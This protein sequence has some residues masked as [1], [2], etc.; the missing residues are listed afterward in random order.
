MFNFWELVRMEY[1]KLFQRKLVWVTAILLT[2]VTIFAGL[3]ALLGDVYVNGEKV[4]THA[5]MLRTDSGYARRL[6]GELLDDPLLD[7]MQ[8]AYGKVPEDAEIYTAT[9]EYQQYARPY[10]E[11]YNFVLR[12]ANN[13]WN[14]I[15][16]GEM[17][18]LRRAAVEQGW[19]KL[20]L[21]EAEKEYLSG[22]EGQLKLPL[23]Y[24]YD[25]G[26]SNY[27]S[28]LYM[29]ALLMMLGVSVCV[30]QIF[31]EEYSRKT[32]PLIASS[33]FGKKPLYLAKAF[34][35]LTF[36]LGLALLLAVAAA[37]SVFSVYGTDGFSAALQ[38]DYPMLSWRLTVGEAA[39]L[40]FGVYLLSS[41]LFAA[42]AMVLSLVFRGSAP[43]MAILL[44]YLLLT[45]VF[46]IPDE[47][48]ILSQIWSYLPVNSANLTSALSQRLLQ[49]GGSFFAGWQVICLL[50]P[51]TAAI[52]L[53][54]G[55][56]KYRRLPS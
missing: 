20:L 26:Y 56:R 27:L 35:G 23:T 1:R 13:R 33:S 10:S 4:D 34:T 14:T 31:S 15:S 28:V 37:A 7:K 29:A 52:L 16:A 12:I 38:L 17:Y 11:I 21:S 53:L 51:V 48:R 2:A 30:P 42:V 54:A 50:Y 39:L 19:T 49:V 24:R 3:S 36:S 6:S 5:N 8:E 55:Y 46:H 22:Q 32:A 43:P 45:G 18:D 40:L 9:R 47:Y 25:D 41:L 44:G